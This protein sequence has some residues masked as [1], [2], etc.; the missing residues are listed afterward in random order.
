MEVVKKNGFSNQMSEKG[1]VSSS[2]IDSGVAGR[3]RSSCRNVEL[4]DRAAGP[5]PPKRE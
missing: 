1:N 3:G 4:I 5:K 2:F